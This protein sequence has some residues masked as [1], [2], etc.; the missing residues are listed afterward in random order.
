M[1]TRGG[2]GGRKKRVGTGDGAS[3]EPGEGA[4]GA[5]VGETAGD[6]REREPSRRGAVATEI[7]LVGGDSK[8]GGGRRG[9]I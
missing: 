6:G 3:T 4:R 1:A 5:M 8:D 9:D 7:G 2:S